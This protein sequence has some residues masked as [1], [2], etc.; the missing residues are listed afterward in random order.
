VLRLAVL[1]FLLSACSGDIV[2]SMTLSISLSDGRTCRDAG[3]TSIAIHSADP[4]PQ[5]P[6]FDAEAPRAITATDLPLDDD[7]VIDGLSADGDVLYRGSFVPA[8]VLATPSAVPLRP[9]AA[10]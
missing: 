6:C 4:A 3:V 8:D 5:F 9:F 7:L 1:A 2:P 10:R